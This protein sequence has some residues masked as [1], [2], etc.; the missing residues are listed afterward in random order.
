[1]TLVDRLKKSEKKEDK[2]EEE[3]KIKKWLLRTIRNF[4]NI[5]VGEIYSEGRSY[6]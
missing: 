3:G 5:L 2:E 4:P 6:E 1:M